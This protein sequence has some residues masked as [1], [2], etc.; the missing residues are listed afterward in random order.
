MLDGMRRQRG[1]RTCS[2]RRP[3]RPQFRRGGFCD[4]GGKQS[5]G[6]IASRESGLSAAPKSS[7]R[8]RL[9]RRRL[10][11]AAVRR[12]HLLRA[13]AASDRPPTLRPA[14][15][16]GV[17]C[18]RQ[19]RLPHFAVW[20]LDARVKCARGSS[21][22][23]CCVWAFGTVGRTRSSS[24]TGP[25]RSACTAHL[26]ASGGPNSFAGASP[27]RRRI[28]GAAATRLPRT[29]H[30]CGGGRRASTEAA[31]ELVLLLRG[32]HRL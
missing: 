1:I 32:G 15:G 18:A 4:V 11:G 8:P 21:T 28:V 3:R 20:R 5:R 30:R 26:G 24:L 29:I 27:P 25:H 17:W 19:S 7:R 6:I 31:A 14:G 12:R 23:G 22:V 2:T 13:A 10:R 9:E 16:G